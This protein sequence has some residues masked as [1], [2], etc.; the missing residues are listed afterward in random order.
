MSKAKLEVL[1]MYWDMNLSQMSIR[2]TSR[3]D[4]Q[5]QKLTN[6]LLSFDKRIRDAFLK[7]YLTQCKLKHSIAF[8]QWRNMFVPTSN[9]SSR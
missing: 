4:K 1:A 2:A 3:K 6:Y 5:M 8:F 7:K 9:V